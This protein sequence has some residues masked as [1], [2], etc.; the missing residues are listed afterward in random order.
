MYYK[1][2]MK[3]NKYKELI[4][5]NTLANSKNTQFTSTVLC[6]N[7]P[8][9]IMISKI[10]DNI[11]PTDSS[12]NPL[13][14]KYSYTIIFNKE[15]IEA[16]NQLNIALKSI[17][18]NGY[19]N[20]VVEQEKL[21]ALYMPYGNYLNIGHSPEGKKYELELINGATIKILLRKIC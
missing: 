16:D 3:K 14:M 10:D 12:G 17:D 15:Y 7:Y 5:V 4:L 20:N 18:T 6:N 1:Y 21:S 9:G 19:Y 11:P 2:I 8:I 13:I